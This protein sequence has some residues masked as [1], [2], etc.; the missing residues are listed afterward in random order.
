[1]SRKI[2]NRRSVGTNGIKLLEDNTRPHIHFDVINHLT[3]EG[4][5]VMVHPAYSPNVAPRDYW[6]NDY[7]K[8]N[9][10]DRPN[11][12]SFSCGIQGDEKYSRG[13]I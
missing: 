10:V 8:Y 13:G 4:V 3:G 12:K 6:L 2:G 7:M 9:L 5:N 11:E 1:M